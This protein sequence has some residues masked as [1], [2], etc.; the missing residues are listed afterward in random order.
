MVLESTDLRRRTRL[1]PEAAGLL[2]PSSAESGCD[3]VVGV[4]EAYTCEALRALRHRP[5][6][7]YVRP[8]CCL[9]KRRREEGGLGRV[10]ITRS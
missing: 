1:L 9:R 10:N 2:F 4:D 5:L 8:V 7:G 3:G 6:T